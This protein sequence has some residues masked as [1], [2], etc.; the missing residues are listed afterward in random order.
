L[1]TATGMSGGQHVGR[2][3]APSGASTQPMCGPSRTMPSGPPDHPADRHATADAVGCAAGWPAASAGR[4][5]PAGATTASGLSS[6]R[7]RSVSRRSS[8]HATQADP[9]PRSAG[10]RRSR[11]HTRRPARTAAGRPARV[12]RP[13]RFSLGSSSRTRPTAVRSAVERPD[14]GAVE[15]QRHGQLGP[16]QGAPRTC[17]CRRKARRGSVYVPRPGSG[18]RASP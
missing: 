15:P 11:R 13:G 14:R 18:R 12:A 9:G 17:T 1:A 16:R 3:R 10:P 4:T 8:H 7:A 2:A 5:R 6:P